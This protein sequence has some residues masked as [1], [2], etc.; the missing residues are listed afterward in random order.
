M[1]ASLN[2]IQWHQRENKFFNC[3]QERK[4]LSYSAQAILEMN[5][6]TDIMLNGHSSWYNFMHLNV[7]W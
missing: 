2:I 3:I 6:C 7:V 1:A 5:K 4:T